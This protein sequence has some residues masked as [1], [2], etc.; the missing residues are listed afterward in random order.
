MNFQ[1]IKNKITQIA[2]TYRY[3]NVVTK[4]TL[5]FLICSI[6]QKSFSLISTP[7]FTRLMTQTQYGV[8]SVYLSWL[9]IFTILV[10]FRLDYSVFNKGMSRYSEERDEYASSMLGFTTILTTLL[11]LAYLL[12]RKQINA[13]TELNTPIMLGMILELYVTPAVGFWSLRERYDFR[14]KRV[15]FVT[16]LSA[17]LNMI[18]GI[19]AVL[20]F[21]EKGTARVLSCV[22][23]QICVGIFIYFTIF[24]KGKKFIHLPYVRY[25][26]LFNIPLIPYYFSTYIVEQSDRIMIQKM[27][28]LEAAALY[29]V[30]Y[31]VGGIIKIVSNSISNALIPMQY[32]L[33]EKKDTVRIQDALSRVMLVVAGVVLLF[34]CVAPEVVW[35]MGGEK[36]YE[37]IYVI[38][39]VSASVFFS[40]LVIMLA[41]VEFYFDKNKFATFISGVGAVLNVVLNFLLIPVLGYVVAAYT[42]LL[43]YVV[44]AVG[45]IIYCDRISAQKL[46][47]SVV[48]RKKI[49][50]WGGVVIGSSLLLSLLYRFILIRYAICLL[51]SIIGI[52]NRKAIIALIKR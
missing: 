37:A 7:I 35:V 25:A 42:T 20:F 38:P 27:V 47:C 39:P 24:R 16:I 34:S 29:N 30:A 50:L 26:V 6:I 13:F 17:I 28:G 49:L 46:G 23:A 52:W 1:V 2:D 5:W 33:L 4:A 21:E 18:L 14:Y 36:Y 44:F 43:S 51:L 3:A 32:R 48:D 8:Y 15:V 9:Q 19:A 40:F 45:H 31:T 12:C 41:N 10:T 11:L 22:V